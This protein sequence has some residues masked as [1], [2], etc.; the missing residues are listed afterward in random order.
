MPEDPTPPTDAADDLLQRWQDH[1][2]REA[3]D[4]LLRLE[5]RTLA[6]RL[7]R[8]AGQQL[9]PSVSA[10]DLAQ[11]AVFRMLRQKDSPQFGAPEQ[12][13]AYLWKSAWRL[14]LNRLEKRP[15]QRLS[16]ADSEEGDP[17]LAVTG[18]LSGVEKRERSLA[19]DLALNLLPSDDQQILRLIYF[20]HLDVPASAERLGIQRGA[21]EMRLTRARRRIATK[22]LEWSD[23]I[24]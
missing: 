15:V 10:S 1:D 2:D 6:D 19:L 20:E 21:A 17:Q 7:R 5:V 12:F 3:L 8:R 22:L 24:G 23:V 18:G 4:E 16:Q 9:R 14:L 13:R 11:E